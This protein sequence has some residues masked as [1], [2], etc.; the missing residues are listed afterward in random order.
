MH[1]HERL[2]VII[3]IVTTCTTQIIPHFTFVS[4]TAPQL[5]DRMTELN[6]IKL[7]SSL[8]FLP[9]RRCASA[10][11]CDSDVSVRPSAAR[12]YCA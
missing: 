12:Q 10:G 7:N 3:I 4:F 11:L 2:L 5:I 9:A 1:S 8:W 6:S